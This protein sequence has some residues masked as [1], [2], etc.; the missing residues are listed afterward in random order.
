M[1]LVL[2][3]LGTRSIATLLVRPDVLAIL[4]TVNGVAAV[5]HL[6]AVVDA[7]RGAISAEPRLSRGAMLRARIVV[8]LLV[9]LTVAVHGAIGY[10]GIRGAG[11][12]DAIFGPGG[13]WV[14]PEPS[15][16]PSPSPSA[17]PVP[18]PSPSAR[19]TAR[20][21]RTSSPTPAPTPTPAWAEDGR[22]NLLLIGSDA[23]PD[24]WMLRTDTMIVLSVDVATGRA[25]MFGV[26]RN[27]TGVPLPP[28]SAGAFENGRFPGLLNA[29]YVYAMGHP[30]DFPGGEAR[31]FRAVT[32]AVQELVGVRL[33]GAVVVNL[34]GFVDLVDAVGGLWIDIPA[35]LVDDRYPDP[36][37]THVGR[38]VI[39]AGC[40]HL[41]GE[42][43]LA[44][45]RSRH[46][47]SDYGR[48][49][50]QQLVLLALRNQIDP[51]ALL[52]RIPELLSI[53]EDNLWTTLAVEDLPGLVDLAAR[54]RAGDVT[55]ITFIPPT[56][57]SHLTTAELNRIRD[58]V[59]G[60]FDGAAPSPSPTPPYPVLSP[61][62]T[63]PACGPG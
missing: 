57:P 41:G 28:E 58:V 10:V 40:Q 30:T 5:I 36:D 3:S 4:L 7:W 19:P 8:V 2:A 37:G 63:P 29:L 13:S 21:W 9:A 11:A 23:G 14:I 38:I 50:R 6:S 27:M 1:L 39:E 42:M 43:A 34:N 26:P 31:G 53:A 22:L 46:Q 56:Y 24:R 59:G 35:R 47:D 16:N 32:G 55:T 12:L 49:G 18:T 20:P 25:A 60:V 17:T 62:P 61:S 51:V 33:D 45:A 48:M 44:Y 52:P 54:V 15:T